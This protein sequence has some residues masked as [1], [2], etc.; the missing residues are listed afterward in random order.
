MEE[1]SL[2]LKFSLIHSLQ[3]LMTY[4]QNVVNQSSLLNNWVS[5]KMAGCHLCNYLPVDSR[6]LHV[7][8]E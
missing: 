4:Y 3:A 8:Q 5:V 1:Y 6:M 2:M 7:G